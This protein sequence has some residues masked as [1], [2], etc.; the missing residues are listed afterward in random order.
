[1]ALAAARRKSAVAVSQSSSF[2]AETAALADES[3]T[4][5]AWAAAGSGAG[6]SAVTSRLR[7]EVEDTS[8][9]SHAPLCSRYVLVFD[10]VRTYHVTMCNLNQTRIKAGG[11][12][13]A[14]GESGGDHTSGSS[15][16]V[17]LRLMHSFEQL[18]RIRG[19]VRTQP[20]M[21]TLLS[22]PGQP[23]QAAVAG[24]GA[25]LAAGARCAGLDGQV[26]GVDLLRGFQVTWINAT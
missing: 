9:C 5:D 18:R 7:P 14:S 23:Q 25:V 24:G 2:A 3:D 22:L 16:N 6:G 13:T 19:Q 17:V 10:R 15:M 21:R 12:L 1:M 20:P 8:N 4:S 11:L 26:R